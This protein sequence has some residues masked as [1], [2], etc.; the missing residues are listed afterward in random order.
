MAL[1]K[2]YNSYNEIIIDILETIEEYDFDIICTLEKKWIK[3]YNSNNKEIG[4]NLTSGGDGADY[5]TNNQ[6]SKISED[7]LQN[8]IKLLKQ[9]KTNVYIGNLYNIHPDTVGNINNGKHYKQDDI[10]Y[11]IRKE[12][13]TIEYKEKY[14]SFSNEI[15]NEVLLLLATT[16]WSRQKISDA[17]KVSVSVITN[18][19]VG[20][21]PYCKL[22][23]YTFPIRQTRR[24]ITFSQEEIQ[25]IKLELLN[26]NY[27]IQDIAKH[28]NCSRDTIS[29]INSGKRYFDNNT[30][31][32]I[33]N[34]YPNRGSKKSVSTISG[35]GE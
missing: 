19:N 25:N 35:T 1:Y 18:L 28:F 3:F 7:D 33:R 4:Y 23:N 15:L 5:G 11:P 20:R 8:I 22:T 29:D 9:N 30:N 13:G 24:T 21:H 10:D 2:Y 14:N 27:S 16:S 32:P 34:F 6:A 31:Y 17:T 12:K 26:K